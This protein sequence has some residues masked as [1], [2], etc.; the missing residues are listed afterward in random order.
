MPPYRVG[1]G[2]GGEARSAVA[3]RSS[4]GDL[5]QALERPGEVGEVEQ[6]LARAL[7]RRPARS[8]AR[9]AAAR[10]A[11]AWTCPRRGHRPVRV[12]TAA[13]GQLASP[14]RRSARWPA[15]CRRR[16]ARRAGHG[17]VRDATEVQRDRCAGPAA[18]P[19][20]V[21]DADQR[22]ALPAGRDVA[23]RGGRRPPAA[24]SPRRS[25]PAARAAA[26]RALRRRRPSGRRSGRA[27]RPARRA[28]RTARSTAR[29]APARRTPAR[30]AVSSRHTSSIVVPA[31]GSDAASAARSSP[32]TR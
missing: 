12:E 30:S 22:R 31:G 23:G 10:A 3:T 17:D 7:R 21:D 28:R 8:T 13:A 26:C 29:A 5:R 15:R 20:H 32:G 14:P 11:P 16:P 24:R 1:D 19:Q 18:Q 9:P 4:A 2:P 27:R 25:R 6:F